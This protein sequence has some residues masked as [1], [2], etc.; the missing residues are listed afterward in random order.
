MIKIDKPV[1]RKYVFAGLILWLIQIIAMGLITYYWS[2]T[3]KQLHLNKEFQV[4]STGIDALRVKYDTITHMTYKNSINSPQIAF[5]M[6]K[7][8]HANLKERHQYR[9]QLYTQLEATYQN[10]KTNNIRQLH[11]HLPNSVSFLRFHRPEK[12]GDSLKGVRATI[13][14][15]N[16]THKPVSGFEEGRIFNGFRHVFPIFYHKEFVGTVEISYSFAAIKEIAERLYRVH[17]DLILHKEI[18]EKT[19]FTDEQSNYAVSELGN[20]FYYDKKI[21]TDDQNIFPDTIISKIDQTIAYQLPN[22]LQPDKNAIFISEIDNKTYTLFFIPIKSFDQ[23]Y[24]GY[25]IIY[26][27]DH[28]IPIYIRHFWEMFIAGFFIIS[29]VTYLLMSLYYRLRFQQIVLQE[30][31]YTD[32]LTQIGNRLYI[33]ENL[34]YLLSLSER[35]NTTLSIIF[36]DIDYFKKIN[37]EY[38]HQ[39]GDH[40]LST[41]TQIIKNNLRKSDIIGRWGGEE[42]IIALPN[43]SLGRATNLA[44][45][46]RQLIEKSPFIFGNITCS[47]GVAEHKYMETYEALLLRADEMLYKAKRR[48]RNCVIN[49]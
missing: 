41:L 46:F 20:Q 9:D 12:F 30:M 36:F 25:I 34:T 45:K 15:V 8:K 10:L 7:A 14:L 39:I 4:Y 2:H 35:Q 21:R 27:T 48:G 26:R 1:I 28:E 3:L 23:H 22:K 43:T 40:V 49:Q 32:K 31:A 6:Y 47:F 19:V 38:G 29:L 18:V 37:D 5:L 11:F 44:E 42:F 24:A 13:D 17:C 16:V 33:Q